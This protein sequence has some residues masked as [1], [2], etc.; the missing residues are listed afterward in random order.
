MTDENLAAAHLGPH[1]NRTAVIAY[2]DDVTIILRSPKDIP[3]VQEA[4]PCYEDSSGAKLNIQKSK[5][6]ALGSWDTSHT[7]MGIPYH[8]ELRILGIKMTKT[9]QQSA[10]NSWRAE[11]GKIRAQS[12]D[13]HSRTLSLDQTVLYVHNY[14]LATAWYTAQILPPTQRLHTATKY[15]HGLVPVAGRHLSGPTIYPLQTKR[16]RRPGL[17]TRRAKCRALLC[18]ACQH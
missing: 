9:I 13:A 7:I 8:T 15:G 12:R 11:I 2:V 17:N 10:I 6:M 4:I 18:I 16:T 1:N 3:I 14:L 5:A